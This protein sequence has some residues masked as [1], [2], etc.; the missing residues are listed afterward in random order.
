MLGESN[1]F[2]LVADIPG[3][4]KK[5]C[6][7]R[8]CRDSYICDC[9]GESYC[10]HFSETRE[11]LVHT[12]KQECIIAEKKMT[13]VSLHTVNISDIHST[14]PGQSRNCFFS[15]TE[16]TCA[17]TIDIGITQDCLD[18]LYKDPMKGHICRVRD[19]KESMQCDCGGSQRCSRAKTMNKAWRKTANEGRPGLAVCEPFQSTAYHVIEKKGE[20]EPKVETTPPMMQK[21][22]PETPGKEE[23]LK[24][25]IV[26][27]ADQL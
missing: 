13:V 24:E 3:S 12:G 18:S 8:K 6:S 1:C 5:K 25:E 4:N 22:K 21:E 7:T 20:A 23:E 14:V 27:N 10:E 17:S 16:C 15:D 26:G 11:V 19:C 9:D 2:D